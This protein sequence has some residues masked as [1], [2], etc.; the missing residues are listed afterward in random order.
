MSPPNRSAKAPSVGLDFLT[1]LSYSSALAKLNFNTHTLFAFRVSSI[2]FLILLQPD[3]MTSTFENY[4]YG[5]Y[6]Q[7][8]ISAAYDDTT[9]V[10][11]RNSSVNS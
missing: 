3:G 1:C 6:H 10:V 5:D 11:R 4:F 2:I 7:D 8:N 9:V